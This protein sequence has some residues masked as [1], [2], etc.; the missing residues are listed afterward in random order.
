MKNLPRKKIKNHINDILSISPRQNIEIPGTK[1]FSTYSCLQIYS[2][3][4]EN[5]I[6]L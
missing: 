2:Y 4:L 5:K 6:F 1:Y 3:P